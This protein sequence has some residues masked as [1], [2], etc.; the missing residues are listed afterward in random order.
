MYRQFDICIRIIILR[1]KYFFLIGEKKSYFVVGHFMSFHFLSLMFQIEN[2]D[3]DRA[4]LN[5]VFR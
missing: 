5:I 2:I 3:F 4:V 1:K